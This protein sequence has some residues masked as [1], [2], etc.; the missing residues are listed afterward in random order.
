MLHFA[1]FCSHC[2]FFQSFHPFLSHPVISPHC[3][4]LSIYAYFCH[5]LRSPLTLSWPLSF[6]FPSV[7]PC[8]FSPSLSYPSNSLRLSL[9]WQIIILSLLSAV[10]LLALFREQSP[11]P[12]AAHSTLLCLSHCAA[13]WQ[14][15]AA[16]K[17][18]RCFCCYCRHT[19]R[20]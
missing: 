18:S 6:H 8:A 9:S 4:H 14:G 16:G 2:F 17:A 11:H 12:S 20:M 13:L 15:G 19:A 3:S 10:M 7:F 5:V 1:L